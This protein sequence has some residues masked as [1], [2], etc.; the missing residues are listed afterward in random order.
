VAAGSGASERVTFEAAQFADIAHATPEEVRDAI[1]A[2]LGVGKALV[3]SGMLM[4]RGMQG[5]AGAAI[6]LADGPGSPLGQLGFA[7]GTLTGTEDIELRLATGLDDAADALDRHPFLLVVSTT[8][9]SVQVAGH[10]LPLAIDATTLAALRAAE[11]GLLPGFIGELDE[12]GDALATFDTALLPALF[13]AGTPER[14][15]FAFVV[16]SP[17][18]TGI[19]LTS[20]LF[21]THIVNG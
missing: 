19:E 11:L 16:L 8:P 9:G 13:P 10:T 4:L 21:Q 17:D 20:N 6:T 15:Y 5:G 7:S 2:Q 3:D 14:L 12:H 1:N 18:L